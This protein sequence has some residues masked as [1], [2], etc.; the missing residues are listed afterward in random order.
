MVK[1][2]KKTSKKVTKKSPKVSKKV[3]VEKVIKVEVVQPTVEDGDF[4]LKKEPEVFEPQ[5]ITKVPKTEGKTN[6]E[7]MEIAKELGIKNTAKMNKARLLEVI[8]DPTSENTET[9]PLVNPNDPIDTHQNEGYKRPSVTN[10]QQVHTKEQFK[11]LMEGYKK[12]HPEKYKIKKSSGE[13]DRK[14]KEC[15]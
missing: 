14:L 1:T 13:F 3:V 11:A 2:K 7:L 10:V 5:P 6:K 9:K 12:Q 8:S 4:K 15:I